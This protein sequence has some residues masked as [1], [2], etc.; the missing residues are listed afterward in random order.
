MAAASSEEGRIELMEMTSI[1]FEFLRPVRPDLAIMGA[2]AEKYLHS[3]PDGCATKVRIYTENFVQGLYA[4]LQLPE[5]Y[6]ASLFDL[7][8][9]QAFADTVPQQVLGKL[10]HMR[11][12]GNR[13]AHPDPVGSREAE[14][15]F[16]AAYDVGRWIFLCHHNGDPANIP[17][18]KLP[19]KPTAGG[20]EAELARENKALAQ[21]HEVA[22]A[23]LDAL[24]ADLMAERSKVDRL[25]QNADALAALRVEGEKVA[26][27][28]AFSEAETRKNLIDDMLI[29]A[30]WDILDKS[31]VTFEEKVLHQPTQSGEGFADYV[32]WAD[33]GKPLA[34]IEAKRT[35]V[36]ANSGRKQAVCYADGL[37]KMHGQRPVIFYTNGWNTSILDD[38][39][40]FP[41]RRIFGFYAADSLNQLIFQRSNRKP[42]LSVQPKANIA[43]RLYQLEAIKR[44]SE[45]FDNK[46]RRALAVLATGTGKTRIAIS[47]ADV[48]LRTNN[49]KRILFLCDRKEL[50][51]QALGAFKNHLPSAGRMVV[52][53]ANSDVRNVQVYFATYPTMKAV[54]HS[55]DVGFF[56]LIIADESHR[57]IYNRYHDLFLHFD[58]LQVGLTATPVKY[59]E[60]NTYDMF[61]CEDK[62]ATASYDLAQAIE[63]G[64]LVPPRVEIFETKFLREGIRFDDLNEEQREQWHEQFGAEAPDVENTE[65]DKLIFN[66]D[67]NRQILRAFMDR[68]QRDA[69]G[70]S[71]G[72]T[73]IFA[74]NHNHAVLLE[75]LFMEMFPEYGSDFCRVIDYKDKR[76]EQLID[77]FKGLSGKHEITIAISVDMLDT[78]IDVPAIVNLVFAKPVGSFVKFWQ[79]VGRGTR[80]CPDLFGPGKDKQYFTIFDCWSNFDIFGE[81]EDPNPPPPPP[82]LSL[83]GQLF[84]SR[85]KLA[86][87]ALK[88][89]QPR[90]FESTLKHIRAD[91]QALES[92]KTIAVKEKWETIHT[93]GSE[94]SLQS[95]DNKKLAILESEVAPLMRWVDVRGHAPAYR[96]DLM[97]TNGQAGIL[98]GATS[99]EDLRDQVKD[100]VGQLKLNLTQVT[101]KAGAIQQAQSKE[102]WQA[103][104]CEDLEYIRTELRGV[105]KYREDNSGGGPGGLTQ[106]VDIAEDASENVRKTYQVKFDNKQMLAFRRRVESTLL[107][108]FDDNAC[109]QQIKSGEPVTAEQLEALASEVELHDSYLD[110][111]RLH[112]LYPKTA[113]HLDLAIRRI[114]GVDKGKVEAVFQAFAN[115]YNLTPQQL[116]FLRLLKN[117]ICKFGAVELEDL[118]EAPFISL[119][120]EG[121]DG[122]FRDDAQLNRLLGILATFERP[123]TNESSMQ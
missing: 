53:S 36:D 120:S 44:I 95:L 32:L 14:R 19:P 23:Q 109:L 42:A 1:N 93:Y 91:L 82:P 40:D 65:L 2:W 59:I 55:Y 24:V 107:E 8:E 16:K 117:H 77:D 66:K 100:R 112:E 83:R 106:V 7:M 31:Q 81:G 105:M 72:K 84:V 96:F 47:L 25:E 60:R 92:S 114:I 39:Q 98:S 46:H 94:D 108:L 62:D 89:G 5:P 113:G 87:T 86:Q 88:Q 73:I 12:V 21:K 80:L 6:Q 76:A 69:E 20:K 37:E 38:A 9:G 33:N 18:F 29:E 110:L 13:G 3:D 52:T 102:F 78:G 101:E 122:V 123:H 34:V 17:A 116:Q 11:K 85:L 41:P 49:A 63:G 50:R 119:N 10:H 79:M 67:T 75:K 27:A 97:L 61:G 99:K 22:E 121:V 71:I 74:R 103:P 51:K 4:T 54:C 115:E 57:S 64:H 90:V 35:A 111:H 104:T 30:G 48:L 56:D 118:E 45:R 15:I 68:G 43:G 28:L 70:A 58:A 26:D